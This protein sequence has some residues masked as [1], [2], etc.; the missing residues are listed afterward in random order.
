MVAR[1]HL[2]GDWRELKKG[3][4][5]FR[6]DNGGI[7][8]W[9]HSSGTIV[10]QGEKSPAMELRAFISVASAK[11]RLEWKYSEAASAADDEIAVLRKL[12]TDALIEN[13]SLRARASRA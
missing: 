8:N 5:Q 9:W 2:S 3:Q 7:L 10:F 11:G 13:G 6:T 4:L 12:L 1:T